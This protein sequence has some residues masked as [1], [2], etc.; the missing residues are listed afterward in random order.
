MIYLEPNPGTT[1][2]LCI[3]LFNLIRIIILFPLLQ[4]TLNSFLKA[5][6]DIYKVFLSLLL[7]MLFYSLFGLYL[8]YGLEENRC[9]ATEF[10]SQNSEVWPLAFQAFPTFCGDW[11]CEMGLLIFLQFIKN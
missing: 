2:F 9:R 11:Q 6:V 1:F 4:K 7:L 3:R 10:P 5:L 8:F